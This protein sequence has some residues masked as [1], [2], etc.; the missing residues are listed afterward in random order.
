MTVNRRGLLA[1]IGAFLAAPAIIR[2]PGLLMPVKPVWVSKLISKPWVEFHSTVPLGRLGFAIQDA[3]TGE[4]RE[5]GP[6]SG[7]YKAIMKLYSTPLPWRPE[8]MMVSYN[9]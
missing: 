9:D 4:W 8:E 2:T 7:T 3:H 1:G 5:F 6:S